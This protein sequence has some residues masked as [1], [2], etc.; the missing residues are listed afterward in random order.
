[1]AGPGLH[2]LPLRR[3]GKGEEVPAA[4]DDGKDLQGTVG[5]QAPLQVGGAVGPEDAAGEVADQPLGGQGGQRALADAAGAAE[6][7]EPFPVPQGADQPGQEPLTAAG[8]VAGEVGA[9]EAELGGGGDAVEGR[10]LYRRCAPSPRRGQRF[11]GP[12]PQEDGEVPFFP[13]Q[14]ILGSLK[15]LPDCP[16]GAQGGVEGEQEGPGRLYGLKL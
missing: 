14:G 8:R 12:L 10:L 1:M 2:R 6:D 15:G 13:W 11:V 4:Q 5:V 9:V 16:P 3:P 7:D